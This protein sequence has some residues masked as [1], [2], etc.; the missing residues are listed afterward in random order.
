L[1]LDKNCS[2]LEQFSSSEHKNCG[3]EHQ[4]F[5]DGQK[6]WCPKQQFER[7]GHHLCKCAI[8]VSDKQPIVPA[9]AKA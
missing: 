1:I 5:G 3:S 6:N 4:R 7:S 8:P 9:C 2:G